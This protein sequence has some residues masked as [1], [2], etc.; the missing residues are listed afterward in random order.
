MAVANGPANLCVLGVPDALELPLRGLGLTSGFAVQ[1]LGNCF[2]T[3]H[4]TTG[5]RGLQLKLV[6]VEVGSTTTAS[7]RS[8]SRSG[9]SRGRS[10]SRIK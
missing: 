2:S 8:R 4:L 6:A 7:S 9:R 3:R 10:R 5:I 1:G